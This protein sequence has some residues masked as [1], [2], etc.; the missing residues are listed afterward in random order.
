[1][2]LYE[3]ILPLTCEEKIIVSLK[4][5]LTLIGLDY[6]EPILLLRNNDVITIANGPTY[7]NI[8]DL[9]N[10]LKKALN[11]EL[12]LDKSITQDIGY[13][14]NKY[15]YNEN[16]E[17][18][19]IKQFQN[20][21][22]TW[23]GYT[24]LLWYAY[25]DDKAYETWIYNDQNKNIIL[26]ITPAYPYFYCDKNKEPNYIS[27][28]KWIKN[29]QPYI[30]IHIPHS[31]ALKWLQTAEHIIKTVDDNIKRWQKEQVSFKL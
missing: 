7:F 19:I 23:V 17:G 31:T 15:N 25:K 9:H 13:L 12:S 8:L 28:K 27:Y 2:N 18:F 16:E 5:S 4:D 21:L 10:F 14:A 26:E 22:E 30:T 6:A 1:M 24:N 11:N 29:Y 3:I 20:G